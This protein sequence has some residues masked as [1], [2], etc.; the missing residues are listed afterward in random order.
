LQSD[1]HGEGYWQ[2]LRGKAGAN[3]IRMWRSDD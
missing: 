1:C 3:R 2:D